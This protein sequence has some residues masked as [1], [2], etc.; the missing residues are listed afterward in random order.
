VTELAAVFLRI[1][2]TTVGGGE[3][4]VAAFQRELGRRGWLSP[5]QFGIAYALA[6]LTPGTNMLAFCAAAGWYVLGF[7]G[8][9][10]GVVAVT[11]PSSVLVVWL[12]GV[13]EMGNRIPWLRAAVNATIAAGIGTMLAAVLLLVRGQVSKTN[14]LRPAIIVAGAFGLR[15]LGLSPLLTLGIAALSGLLFTTRAKS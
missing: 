1:G 10:I 15:Q 4:T 13:C 5:E 11:I 9:V 12:T 6:R 3:P 7:A 14:W 2:N 8:S